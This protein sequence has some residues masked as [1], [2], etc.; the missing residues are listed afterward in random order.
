MCIAL[1]HRET[2]RTTTQK[3]TSIFDGCPYTNEIVDFFSVCF[4]RR[5]KRNNKIDQSSSGGSN[6]DILNE[7][8]R[9]INKMEHTIE[10]GEVEKPHAPHS[11]CN[12][13]NRWG[14]I[15]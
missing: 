13:N 10:L 9:W 3:Y 15:E 1:H 11:S 6:D 4:S 8:G 12:D 5:E 7:F 2:K 14:K